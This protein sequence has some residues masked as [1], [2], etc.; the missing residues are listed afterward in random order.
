VSASEASVLV[1][2][3]LTAATAEAKTAKGKELPPAIERS[4]APE[5]VNGFETAG[6]RYL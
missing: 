6:T 1:T 2:Q 5:R 3:I 4:R